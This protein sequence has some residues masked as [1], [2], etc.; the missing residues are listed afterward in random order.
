M[1]VDG[2][3]SPSNLRNGHRYPAAIQP[4]WS[5]SVTCSASVHAR[6]SFFPANVHRHVARDR[7]IIWAVVRSVAIL[8]LVHYDIQAPVEVVFNPRCEL[9]PPVIR[10]GRADFIGHAR[11]AP[12]KGQAC[13]PRPAVHR[14]QR[15]NPQGVEVVQVGISAS[16]V[17]RIFGSSLR[18]DAA[19][20]LHLTCTRVELA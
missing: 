17:F 3:K 5:G 10:I 2:A 7:E 6:L 12:R 20:P 4:C 8:V 1:R 16:R 15:D 18:S 13:L 14:R 19:S 9:D 11:T